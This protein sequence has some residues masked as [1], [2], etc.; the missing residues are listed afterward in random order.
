MKVQ[1]IYLPTGKP[2]AVSASDKIGN[3]L[4]EDIRER[5]ETAVR[6]GGSFS[7]ETYG[8]SSTTIAAG[9]L[10]ECKIEPVA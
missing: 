2:A 8:N 9:A 5:F 6:D 7:L 10:Q 1:V 3:D 4:Y